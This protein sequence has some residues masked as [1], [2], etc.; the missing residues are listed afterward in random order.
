[1]VV[2]NAFGRLK[3]RWRC[4]MKTI[5]APT[6]NIPGIVGACV[7]L[8]YMCEIYS[9]HCLQEWMVSD[10]ST[11]SPVNPSPTSSLISSNAVCINNAIRDHTYITRNILFAFNCS[12]CNSLIVYI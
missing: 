11:I 8:H 12:N 4:L 2:E 9:T 10:T 3:G 1:M 6:S 7:V 5:D